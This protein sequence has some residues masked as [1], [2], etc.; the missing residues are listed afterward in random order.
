[1]GDR[2][3]LHVDVAYALIDE[4]G[5]LSV[6]V[7]DEGDTRIAQNTEAITKGSGQKSF[8]TEFVVPNTKTVQV[9]TLV[10]ATS[11]SSTSVVD[12]WAFTVVPN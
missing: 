8:E 1:V 3:T 4:S 11:Q 5:S 10:A 2:V 12:R 7:Q 9:F 6:V